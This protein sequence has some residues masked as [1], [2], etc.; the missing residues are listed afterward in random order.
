[1]ITICGKPYEEKVQGIMRDKHSGP[2]LNGRGGQESH[3][4]GSD[5]KL[6]PEIWI[7]VS[8]IMK[9][10]VRRVCTCTSYKLGKSCDLLRD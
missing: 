2:K 10:P 9:V 5:L 1:M 7:R 6:R 8:Y 3:L 4:W